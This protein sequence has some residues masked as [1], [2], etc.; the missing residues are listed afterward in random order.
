MGCEKLI[1][2]ILCR[3]EKILAKDFR[4]SSASGAAIKACLESWSMNVGKIPLLV[5]LSSQF[6][7]GI[8]QF[9]R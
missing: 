3:S 1:L 4:E 9:E 6:P 7:I 2:S 5:K 8:L